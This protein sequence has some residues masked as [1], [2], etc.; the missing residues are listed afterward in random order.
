M[1]NQV[2]ASLRSFLADPFNRVLVIFALILGVAALVLEPSVA[3][4]PSSSPSNGTFYH[5]FYLSSCPHCHEQMNELHPALQKEFNLTIAYHEVSMPVEKEIFESVRKSAGLSG[6]V[7]TTLVGN[8]TFVGYSD[9]TAKEIKLA[10]EE[11]I[12]S[13]CSDPLANLSGNLTQNQQYVFDLPILGQVDGKTASL[14]ILAVVLGLIDGFNPCA[15]WVL[16]Y[17]ISLTMTMNDRKRIFLVVGSFVFA[18]GVLYFLFMTAW[19]NAFLFVGYLRPVTVLVGT[20]AIVGG[21]LNVKQY[22][23]SRKEGLKCEVVDP[24]QHAKIASQAQSI[25][26]APITLSLLF[27]IILLAFVVNSVEFVCS[28][29][30]P[31]VFTQILALQNLSALEY[32]FYILLYDFFFMLDDMI[33]F[34]MAAFTISGSVGE[35]YAQL[36]KLAGGALL[37]L[38]GAI[39]LFF[40]KALW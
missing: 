18:S 21:V 25:A 3:Q 12:K 10:V 4:L 1:F 16:V 7:P 29:A 39:L 5:F 14:P 26:T 13:G 31:A 15:M 34:G 6:S 33:I 24:K 20:V 23:E 37:V 35:K 30:I 9:K 36:C 22:W 40:P 27:S 8:R 17:L 19:L 28:S 2:F 38:L 11:C 32:Y